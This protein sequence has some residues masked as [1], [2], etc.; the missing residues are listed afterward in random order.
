MMCDGWTGVSAALMNAI[1][2]FC[3]TGGVS[4]D[5]PRLTPGRRINQRGSNACCARAAPRVS[6]PQHAPHLEAMAQQR[7]MGI[8]AYLVVLQTQQ[9]QLQLKSITHLVILNAVGAEE[10]T[11]VQRELLA[12]AQRADQTL[13][14]EVLR[15]EAVELYHH[16]ER[17]RRT[18]KQL[19][20]RC[21]DPAQAYTGPGREHASFP[22]G[23]FARG[24]RVA[25]VQERLLS[26]GRAVKAADVVHQHALRVE[27]RDQGLHRI[28]RHLDPLLGIAVA[29]ATI[30]ERDDLFF[31]D[32]EQLVALFAVTEGAV[33]FRS[34][35]RD[36]PAVVAAVAYA[37]P[38]VEHAL[39]QDT[40][41]A[42]LLS[43][44]TARLERILRRV[45]PHV[46][47]RDE[48]AA[49]R[50]V[51]AFEQDD[52]A[53]ELGATREIVDG[54]DDLLPGAVIGGEA[55]LEAEHQGV[56]VVGGQSARDAFDLRG[57]QAAAAMLT[58][59]ALVHLFQQFRFQRLT[60]T[61]KS[62]FG[63]LVDA[64]PIGFVGELVAPLAAEA[65]VEQAHP[66]AREK[67]RYVHA[68]GDIGYGI[69][70]ERYLRPHIAFLGRG[71][72]VVDAAHPVVK[73]RAAQRE[74]GLIEAVLA[75]GT[76][77]E[78][79]E[80]PHAHSE[81]VDVLREIAH[82]Q[83]L[84]EDVVT[85]GYRRVRGEH[86]AGRD[87]LACNI[88]RQAALH[89]LAYALE[90]LECGV[91][92]VDVPDGRLE[93]ERAQ[94]AYAAD[95]E[96]DLLLD[97]RV[98]VAAVQLIGDGAVDVVV[99]RHVAVEQIKADVAGLRLPH[100]EQHKPN[101]DGDK[102]VQ[103]LTV[104]VV[105]GLHRQLIEIGGRV[106]GD[107]FAVAVEG[108][109]EITLAIEHAHGDERNA[110]VARRLA[111]IAREDAEAAGVDGQTLVQAEFRA[112]IGDEGGARSQ[113]RRYVGAHV[114]VM[115]RIVGGEGAIEVLDE[116]AVLRGLVQALLRDAAQKGLGVVS[117]G[118]P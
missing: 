75:A 76:A 46:D 95:A 85:R 91:A 2:A 74:R 5:G 92:F 37:P 1:P 21:V 108:L 50:E 24:R 103:L 99:L 104:A 52:L 114:L 58:Q 81:L 106:V 68:V 13:H 98:D 49:E 3:A 20:R 12:V 11:V 63:Y 25:I 55:P 67:G 97:A 34:E 23:E 87:E 110:E 35:W 96:H 64:F 70:L 116:D 118:L 16:L 117:A 79:E 54:L 38:A 32:I 31:E 42:G 40:V 57:A 107:L 88:E 36:G 56:G 19:R 45:Q 60:Q 30:V 41:D 72:A 4:K 44:C 48:L 10:V 83:M 8:D 39:V 29:V 18:S 113:V 62:V 90:N 61:P 94:R 100:L 115:I 89:V 27:A 109:R 53:L 82:H 6:K 51:V 17:K 77:A 28:L 69:F 71:D 9:R 66:L 112:E 33:V 80:L 15:R 43:G 47:A 102:H 86:G 22:G 7:V 111:V 73:T 84:I 59:H 93:A 78:R 26:A 65:H 14:R 105:R 101:N